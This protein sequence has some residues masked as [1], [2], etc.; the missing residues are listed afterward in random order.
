[1]SK[2]TEQTPKLGCDGL[3]LFSV[4]PGTTDR[5]HH[6]KKPVQDRGERHGECLRA[7]KGV[8]LEHSHATG[9]GSRYEKS[10]GFKTL[11]IYILQVV[12]NTTSF[13]CFDNGSYLLVRAVFRTIITLY[14]SLIVFLSTCSAHQ[15]GIAN[16]I[17]ERSSRESLWRLSPFS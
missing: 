7:C 13:V 3:S 5:P 17:E 12:F 14:K 8:W 11:L 4:F 16:L 9:T 10:Q 6:K 1:M 15:S 2:K